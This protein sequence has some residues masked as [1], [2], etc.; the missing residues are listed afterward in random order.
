VPN[1]GAYPSAGLIQAPNGDF[2]G[3]TIHQA[4]QT[5]RAGGT[6]F[7]MTA[8]GKVSI[9]HRLGQNL[10]CGRV[11]HWFTTMDNFVGIVSGAAVFALSNLGRGWQ[12]SIW[13]TFTSGRNDGAG[14]VGAHSWSRRYSLSG[15]RL[16]RDK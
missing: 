13:L 15:D 11:A 6:I 3:R 1:D 10:I 9:I 5:N 16:R 2:Y 12:F 8:A 14:A 4:R 7:K